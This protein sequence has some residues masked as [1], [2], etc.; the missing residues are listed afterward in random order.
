MTAFPLLTYPAFTSLTMPAGFQAL[1]NG[2]SIMSTGATIDNTEAA[3]KAYDRIVLE[4][5]L[6]SLNPTGVPMLDAALVPSYD[7]TNYHTLLGTVFPVGS[8][9]I[10]VSSC[11][12]ETGAATKRGHIKFLDCDP[13]KYRVIVRNATNVAFAASGNT[14]GWSGT[15]YQTR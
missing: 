11:N 13:I 5:I 10:P 6:G 12:I 15:L 9:S 8:D 4:I 2:A 14:V 3:G 1:A 7:G